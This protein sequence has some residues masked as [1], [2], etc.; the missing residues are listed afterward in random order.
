MLIDTKNNSKIAQNLAKKRI[1]RGFLTKIE[2]VLIVDTDIRPCY[3][4]TLFY[5]IRKVK[6]LIFG[7]DRFSR[8]LDDLLKLKNNELLI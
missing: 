3:E 4:M 2:Q 6:D 8:H 5:E 7:T 1:Q